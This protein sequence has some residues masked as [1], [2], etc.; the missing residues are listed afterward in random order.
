M[1]V[2]ATI[3]R[4]GD[5]R[6]I[7]TLPVQADDEYRSDWYVLSSRSTTRFYCETN[8]GEA[9]EADDIYPADVAIL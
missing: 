9:S 3:P 2:Q 6:P 8:K 1:T 7:Q 4:P 5:R